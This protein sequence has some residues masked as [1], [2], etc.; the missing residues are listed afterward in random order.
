M[1]APVRTLPP[2]PSLEHL[3]RQ[4]RDLQRDHRAAVPEALERVRAHTLRLADAADSEVVASTFPRT[5]A[6]LV[7][8]RSRPSATPTHAGSRHVSKPSSL[9]APN[10]ISWA[11]SCGIT[12]TMPTCHRSAVPSPSVPRSHGVPSGSP[13]TTSARCAMRWS[14]RSSTLAPSGETARSWTSTAATL[15]PWSSVWTTSQP[16]CTRPSRR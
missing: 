16:W 14:T 10:S 6:Q 4:A 12:R 8:D 3:R 1:S 5:A 7:I 15:P 13:A 11:R 9:P 2:N